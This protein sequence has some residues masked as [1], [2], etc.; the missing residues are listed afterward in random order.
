LLSHRADGILV[1]AEVLRD[2]SRPDEAA[3]SARAALALYERKGNVV[4][5][6]RARTLLNDEER[7]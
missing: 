7:G 5:A 3:E 1:L 2:G 4:G 6:G